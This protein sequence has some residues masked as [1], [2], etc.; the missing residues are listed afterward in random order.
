VHSASSV[1]PGITV[2]ARTLHL[3]FLRQ[4][5]YTD[6]RWGGG[7]WGGSTK[8]DLRKGPLF[9]KH[10]RCGRRS[11]LENANVSNYKIKLNAI[12]HDHNYTKET[13]TSEVLNIRGMFKG[14]TLHSHGA[15]NCRRYTLYSVL[16][17]EYVTNALGN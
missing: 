3:N 13:S 4:L 1:V 7:G 15:L 17:H 2:Q 9:S 6:L 10:E 5:N 16:R 8:R 11:E 14:C 12:I